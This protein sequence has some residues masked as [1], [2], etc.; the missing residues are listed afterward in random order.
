MCVGSQ[1]WNC[2]KVPEEQTKPHNKQ[3]T[4]TWRLQLTKIIMIHIT[5]RS[6]RPVFSTASLE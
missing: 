4:N 2:L 3:N 6:L 1:N 5:P